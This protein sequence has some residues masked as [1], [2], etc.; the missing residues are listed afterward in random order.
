MVAIVRLMKTL[1]ALFV[2]DGSFALWIL[3]LLVWMAFLTKIGALASPHVTMALLV[4]GTLIL[5]LHNV[6]KAS[7]RGRRRTRSWRP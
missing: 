7:T 2:D 1:L 6:I 3:A 4:G 5:L